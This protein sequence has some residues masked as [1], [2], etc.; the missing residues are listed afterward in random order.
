[1]KCMHVFS[2]KGAELDL[3]RSWEE[4]WSLAGVMYLLGRVI[5]TLTSALDIF[6]TTL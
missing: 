2:S 4:E 1:M 3:V 6:P 5:P